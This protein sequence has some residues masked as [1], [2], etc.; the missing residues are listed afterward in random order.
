MIR[1]GRRR[2]RAGREPVVAGA[3]P[4]R[5]AFLEE[6]ESAGLRVVTEAFARDRAYTPE[7]TLVPRTERARR[8]RPRRRREA[9]SAVGHDGTIEAIDGTPIVVR[10]RRSASTATPPP[11]SRWPRRSESCS[12]PRR[13]T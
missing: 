11:R 13:F 9:G 6:A 7:G 1:R 12:T 10:R 2:R 3:R 8:A 5:S 4:A